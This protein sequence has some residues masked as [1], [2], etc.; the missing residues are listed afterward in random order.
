[1]VTNVGC[2][3]KESE[4]PNL[5][6]LWMVVQNIPINKKKKA[7]LEKDL[8]TM[9]CHGFLERPWCLCNNDM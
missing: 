4:V 9:D 3:N 5:V 1:M 7:L 8:C 2:T 6:L